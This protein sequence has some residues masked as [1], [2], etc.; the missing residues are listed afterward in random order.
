MILDVFISST[1]GTKKVVPHLKLKGCWYWLFWLEECQARVLLKECW[2]EK[3]LCCTLWNCHMFVWQVT[4]IKCLLLVFTFFFELQTLSMPSGEC[5]EHYN[6]FTTYHV[7]SL[8]SCSKMH[9]TQYL[10]F[11]QLPT[12]LFIFLGGWM[13]EGYVYY[14]VPIR[15]FPV[16]SRESLSVKKSR[17]NRV[18]LPNVFPLPVLHSNPC[19]AMSSKSE[20]CSPEVYRLQV[21]AA[22]PATASPW[23]AVS[24]IGER[25]GLG[26]LVVAFPSLAMFW[27]ECST[28][29]S[30]LVLFFF[31]F[32]SGD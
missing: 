19:L 3:H 8:K 15:I 30:T 29:H 16:G 1:A 17:C 20:A 31:F 12:P 9:I 25:H 11:V 21:L 28:T 4:G 32:W 18:A 27:G 23:V 7:W 2:K 26:M 6:I 14:V 5:H 24:G 13:G 10:Y 22:N